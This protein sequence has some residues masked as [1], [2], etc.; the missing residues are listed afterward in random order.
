MNLKVNNHFYDLIDDWDFDIYFL[1]GGYGS[2]KSHETFT[3]VAIKAA[4]EKRKVA[5]VRREYSTIKDSCYADLEEAIDRI[6]MSDFTKYLKSPMRILLNESDIIFRGMDKKSKIKSIKGIDVIIVEEANE[7][8]I[9]KLKELIN[10][11]RSVDKRSHIIFMTNPGNENDS[12]AQLLNEFGVDLEELYNKRKLTI[13]RTMQYEGKEETIKIKLHHSVYTDNKFLP[14]LFIWNLEQEQDEEIKTIAKEGRYGKTKANVFTNVELS[15][16]IMELMKNKYLKYFNGQDYG[17]SVSYD[18]E[19]NMAVD[20]KENILYIY[21]GFYAR[22]LDT[23]QLLAL[24]IQHKTY[25]RDTIGDSASPRFIKDINNRGMRIRGA[26][27]PAGSVKYG[28]YKLKGFTKIIISS[29]LKDMVTEK[30]GVKRGI[31]NDF[32]ELARKKLN[33]GLYSEDE[34]TIDPHAVDAARYG[35]EDWER[36]NYKSRIINKSNM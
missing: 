1:I 22:E 19:V 14:P 8:E 31:Y 25:Q 11:L 32:K 4:Q 15:D 2:G 36:F 7:L 3:K 30:N 16:N 21:D 26:S 34:W 29:K 33:N 6:G 12:I 20:E 23:E 9:D 24:M 13:E 5:V 28:I 35:L 27:K 10:R 17:F 18:T